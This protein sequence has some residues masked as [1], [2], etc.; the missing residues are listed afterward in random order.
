MKDLRSLVSVFPEGGTNTFTLD[1]VELNLYPTRGQLKGRRP[2]YSPERSVLSVISS[3]PLTHPDN[4]WRVSVERGGLSC[5]LALGAFRGGDGSRVS[6][7][8]TGNVL[9]RLRVRLRAEDLISSRSP[10]PGARGKEPNFI[11][12][13][14]VLPGVDLHRLSVEELLLIIGEARGH[15]ADLLHEVFG[16]RLD[17]KHVGVS[18]AMVELNWDRY[19][20]LA[21]AAPTLFWPA[22]RDAFYGASV[23]RTEATERREMDASPGTGVLSALGVHG[24]RPKLYAKDHRHLRYEVQLTGARAKELLGHA[25][26][27]GSAPALTEDLERLAGPFYE[28]LMQAQGNLTCRTMLKLSE[29]LGGFGKAGL[30]V[31]KAFESGSKFFNAGGRHRKALARLTAR[32]WVQHESRGFYVPGPALARTLHLASYFDR[33]AGE[34]P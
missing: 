8:V 27:L 18:I 2:P 6:C 10:A 29:L 22:W 4:C 20:D 16:L 7:A 31:L 32:G 9:R 28:K 11:P 1:R 12:P 33:H 13:G 26:R 30:P 34:A 23:G 24:G 21:Q 14:D 5:F 25:I 19:S 17:P 15:Y 3:K